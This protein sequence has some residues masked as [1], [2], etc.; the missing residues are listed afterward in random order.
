M[1]SVAQGWGG[2][3]LLGWEHDLHKPLFLLSTR[4][5]HGQPLQPTAC[6][7]CPAIPPPD[8]QRKVAKSEAKHLSFPF[9]SEK[10]LSPLSSREMKEKCPKRGDA[11]AEGTKPNACRIKCGVFFLF[12]FCL[13]QPR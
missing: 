13:Q 9:P 3:K 1:T 11:P 2:G 7:I 4:F 12:Y 10:L 5:C 8:H 6:P